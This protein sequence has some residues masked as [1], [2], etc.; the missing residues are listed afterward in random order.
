MVDVAPGII[1]FG[2]GG[3]QANMILGHYHLGFFDVEIVIPPTPPSGGGG[4]GT[5]G[6]AIGSFPD[7]T[8]DWDEDA[9]RTIIIRIK[10]GGKTTEKIYLVSAKRTEFIIKLL[11]IVNITRS[12][13]K[14]GV[15]NLRRQMVSVFVKIKNF[16]IKNDD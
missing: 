8:G 5:T 15:K 7:R 6:G 1:T 3:D 13:I 2:L 9:A 14:V 16:G 11:N 12:K 10:H 4:G